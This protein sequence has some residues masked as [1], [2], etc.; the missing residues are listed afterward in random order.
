MKKEE[1][2]LPVPV[3]FGFWQSGTIL[4]RFC[5]PSHLSH[6]FLPYNCTRRALIPDFQ[7]TTRRISNLRAVG[8]SFPFMKVA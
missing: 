3:S 7:P 8:D 2:G 1:A 5:G 6:H 4:G